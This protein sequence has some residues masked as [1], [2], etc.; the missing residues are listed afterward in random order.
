MLAQKKYTNNTIWQIDNLKKLLSKFKNDLK[1]VLSIILDMQRIYTEYLKEVNKANK[2]FD[3]ICIYIL[4]L[5]QKLYI[6]N[7]IK[8]DSFF[9]SAINCKGQMLKKKD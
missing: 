8:I 4:R 9:S 1:E 5:E 6:N 3:K 2:K 7:K